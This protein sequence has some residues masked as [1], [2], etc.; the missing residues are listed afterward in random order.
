MSASQESQAAQPAVKVATPVVEEAAPAADAEQ[1]TPV[2]DAPSA[3]ANEPALADEPSASD[4]DGFDV[5]PVVVG[6]A[7]NFPVA[8]AS[9][10]S[11][12]LKP[13]L[14]VPEHL[15]TKP[16]SEPSVAEPVIGPDIARDSEEP[17]HTN[18]SAQHAIE[19]PTTTNASVVTA[20]AHV[21]EPVVSRPEVEESVVTPKV[22][23]VEEQLAT[24]SEP[25]PLVEG[26]AAPVPE[27]AV[28]V[29]GESVHPTAVE[30]ET[31]P[32]AEE[33]DLFTVDPT[34]STDASTELPTL[35]AEPAPTADVVAPAAD[36]LAE[37]PAPATEEPLPSSQTTVAPATADVTTETSISVPA[38]KEPIRVI[39]AAPAAE[40]PSETLTPFID[41]P[42]PAPPTDAPI[43]AEIPAETPTEEPNHVAKEVTPA[44][45]IPVESPPEAGELD[46]T[47]QA[48][49]SVGEETPVGIPA[50][51]VE[52]PIP[53]TEVA[54]L[55]SEIIVEDQA[56]TTDEPTPVSQ[57]PIPADA[58]A[59]VGIPEP[60]AE[61]LVPVNDEVAA[62]TPI[63][64]SAL[65][66]EETPLTEEAIPAAEIPVDT[67]V[68]EV[69][70]TLVA[71]E[72]AHAAE[73]PAEIRAPAPEEPDHVS[74]ATAP[75]AAEPE[76]LAE[77]L[78][79]LAEEP[80]PVTEETASVT[81][82]HTENLT[83]LVEEPSPTLQAVVPA[84]LTIETPVPV[85]E[86]QTLAT[87]AAPNADTPAETLAVTAEPIPAVAPL[88]P[89]ETPV[90][91]QAPELS[92]PTSAPETAS[93]AE[94]PSPVTEAPAE[95]IPEE[96]SLV[97]DDAAETS[98][99]FVP[100]AAEE[101]TPAVP[102]E[103]TAE[104]VPDVDVAPEADE[105]APALEQSAS[106]VV[107]IP[108]PVP[109]EPGPVPE[110]EAVPGVVE[111]SAE[112]TAP[113]AEGSTIT[114]QATLATI[115]TPAP[116]IEESTLTTGSPLEAD[117]PAETPAPVPGEPVPVPEESVPE[118]SPPTPDAEQLLSQKGSAARSIEE[119]APPAEEH[120]SDQP[121]TVVE[122]PLQ[123]QVT[124]QVVQQEPV[125]HVD[126]EA[127]QATEEEPVVQKPES[128][129]GAEIVTAPEVD[130]PVEAPVSN[131]TGHELEQKLEAEPDPAVP[132]E[133]LDDAA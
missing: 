111:H 80:T 97:I 28:P 131:G 104:T 95:P 57:V 77:T 61:H 99:E 124:E 10:E 98:L 119:F 91:I 85:V 4:K 101:S 16:E 126:G 6:I 118:A 112:T 41:E 75:I 120:L 18:G 15:V 42:K 14:E 30:I 113:V 110:E 84:E 123:V 87:E 7:E 92:E 74:Q 56:T 127:P 60:T 55:S 117:T 35:V 76:V 129:P 8:E 11:N 102:E 93:H 125:T 122:E 78:V 32:V 31:P 20:I 128:V 17:L 2:S 94:A 121:E 66:V 36:I 46:P 69:E 105:P 33:P 72:A 109:E 23:N 50:A 59:L 5:P 130:A 63:E 58:R 70:Q 38:E 27:E 73:T 83:P 107:E 79:P 81:N 54:T 48:S 114:E 43:I 106:P 62:T 45:E 88:A 12:V 115:E 24:T 133:K 100:P 29:V 89:S 37:A 39:E 9:V 71:D 34:V 1:P 103:T 19:D 21:D 25:E 86:E 67:P 108:A 26:T 96:H 22:D 90:H 116:A 47:P 65:V 44:A 3:P 40:T 13:A 53:V 132:D 52:E 51:A 82:T 49:A 68:L 64:T